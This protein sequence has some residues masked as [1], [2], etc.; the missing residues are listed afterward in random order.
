MATTPRRPVNPPDA[1]E[2]LFKPAKK[3]P[4]AAVERRTV[5]V[6]AGTVSIRIDGDVLAF[7]RKTALAGRTASTRR[8]AGQWRPRDNPIT[9]LTRLSPQAQ[10]FRA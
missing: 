9:R 1:A 8:F 6:A 7:F 2:A 4:A 10:R 5:P 3:T